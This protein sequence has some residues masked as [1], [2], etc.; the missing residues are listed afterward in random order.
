[1]KAI[2]KPTKVED[3]TKDYPT[4]EVD[5][6]RDIVNVDDDG[7]KRDDARTH[8]QEEEEQI[9]LDERKI[10]EKENEVPTEEFVIDKIVNHKINRSRRHRYAK[11]GEPLYR[12]R[13]YG[14]KKKMTLGNQRNTYLGVRSFHTTEQRRPKSWRASNKPT[15]ANAD[16]TFKFH[17]LTYRRAS[18]VE[19]SFR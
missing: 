11:A 9:I 19:Q 15:T 5:N 1:M 2:M 16:S 14:S 12:V 4:K 8:T 10:S 3:H 18:T 13:W 7:R 6:L 17:V